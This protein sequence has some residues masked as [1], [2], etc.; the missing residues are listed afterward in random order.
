[1]VGER[2]RRHLQLGRARGSGIRQAPSRIEYSEWTWRWT[3]SGA[4]AIGCAIL[5][6]FAGRQ[7][8]AELGYLATAKQ[9]SKSDKTSLVID[10]DK[11]EKAR[12]DPRHVDDRRHRRRRAA[13]RHRLAARRALM[14]RIVRDGGTGPSPEE[15][16]R[17][18]E[19]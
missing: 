15:L 16:R 4:P 12:E 11:V 18:R 3:K 5:A 10:R 19:P 9:I 7:T 17:L 14:E 1:M 8:P 2:D 6:P 13:G